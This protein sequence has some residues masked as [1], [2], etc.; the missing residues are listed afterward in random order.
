V[1]VCVC[2]CN[3]AGTLWERQRGIHFSRR[4]KFGVEY[5]LILHWKNGHQVNTYFSTSNSRRFN[6]DIYLTIGKVD[7]LRRIDVDST[8]KSI[9]ADMVYFSTSNQRQIFPIREASRFINVEHTSIPRRGFP[10]VKVD[11]STM[12]AR[13]FDVEISHSITPVNSSTSN[14]RRIQVKVTQR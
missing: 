10:T 5:T 2:V 12:N 6:V 3:V 14:I 11:F 8:S 9:C 1:C 7:F 4:R 13:L